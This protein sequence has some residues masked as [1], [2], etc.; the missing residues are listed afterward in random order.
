[1]V[2]LNGRL[3]CLLTTL[4]ALQSGLPILEFSL[5]DAERERYFT[6]VRAG[7]DRNYGLMQQLF[8]EVIKM[9]VS[10]N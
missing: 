7:M 2:F 1:M 6:A 3:A 4:M 10:R 9:S 8:N 5:L